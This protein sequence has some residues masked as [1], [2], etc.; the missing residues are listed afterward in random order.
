MSRSIAGDTS[1]AIHT[2]QRD[3]GEGT[4]DAAAEE[5]GGAAATTG[6]ATW[7]HSFFNTATWTQVGGDFA[8]AAVA[9]TVVGPIGAY[10]WD[11][12]AMVTEVQNWL[13]TPAANFGWIL[14]GDESAVS[15]GKR[16]DS[17]ENGTAT[18]RP[19]LTITYSAELNQLFLPVSLTPY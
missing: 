2:V 13:A 8:P 16:F 7:V 9:T 11:S 17:R 14:V 12:P 4:S 3:W 5:G 6:D 18:S 10:T 19:T 15:T 1:V